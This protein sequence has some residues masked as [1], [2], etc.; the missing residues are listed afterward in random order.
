M[1]ESLKNQ[2]AFCKKWQFWFTDMKE[3]THDDMFQQSG[4]AMKE[5]D[6]EI[7]LTNVLANC[8]NDLKNSNKFSC[9]N[10]REYHFM[11]GWW[12]E[13]AMKPI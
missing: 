3:Q 1:T 8:T 10:V 6:S 7:F 9:D 5:G 11:S 4:G 12:R 2:E 13:T